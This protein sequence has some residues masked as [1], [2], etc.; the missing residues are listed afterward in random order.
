MAEGGA[1][2]FSFSSANDAFEDSVYSDGPSES[3][4][5]EMYPND[6]DV[7]RDEEGYGEVI[8]DGSSEDEDSG[9]EENEGNELSATSAFLSLISPEENSG[10]FLNAHPFLSERF[11]SYPRLAQTSFLCMF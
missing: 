9:D 5:R 10:R 4:R 7:Y 6:D 11:V 2:L 8:D 1:D 3:R